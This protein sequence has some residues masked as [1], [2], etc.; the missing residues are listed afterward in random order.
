[1]K[2]NL[3]HFVIR[4]SPHCNEQSNKCVRINYNLSF[5]GDPDKWWFNKK[6]GHQ[7]YFPQ[8]YFDQFVISLFGTYGLEKSKKQQLLNP[9]NMKPH[10]QFMKYGGQSFDVKNNTISNEIRNNIKKY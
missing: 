3:C 10:I 1:M 8:N 2:N 6:R 4:K 5:C 7:E 9:Q